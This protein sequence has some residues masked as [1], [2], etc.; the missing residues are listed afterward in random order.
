MGTTRV[1]HD[2]DPHGGG[3]GDGQVVVRRDRHDQMILRHRRRVRNTFLRL[4][5]CTQSILCMYL[6]EE[7]HVNLSFGFPRCIICERHILWASTQNLYSPPTP[8]KNIETRKFWNRGSPLD[9]PPWLKYLKCFPGKWL[10]FLWGS[11]SQWWRLPVLLS[12]SCY[13]GFSSGSLGHQL[14][15]LHTQTNQL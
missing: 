12:Q 4:T 9:L 2:E 6:M 8:K 11:S 5:P 13:G 3:R 7:V 14:A 15:G 10:W 1:G